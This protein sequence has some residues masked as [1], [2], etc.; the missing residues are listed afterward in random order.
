MKSQLQVL[1]LNINGLRDD[2][3]RRGV[4]YWLKQL[5]YDVILLQDVRC[6]RGDIELWSQEWGMPVLWSEYNAILLTNRSMSI[7]KVDLSFPL[8]RCLVGKISCG[9]VQGDVV[10]GSIYV[11]AGRE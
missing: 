8:E 7:S 9:G 11:P 6:Q 3:R 10:V 1:S 2:A 4:F 5:V